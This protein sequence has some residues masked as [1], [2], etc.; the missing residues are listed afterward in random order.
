M[1]FNVRQYGAVAD[2]VTNDGP[3][4]QRAVDD[5]TAAGG[6]R[7]LVPA[8]R[9]LCGT[10]K[11]K[12][13]VELHLEMGAVLLA[14]LNPADIAMT[15]SPDSTVANRSGYFIGAYHVKNIAITGHGEING[16]GEKV[17]VDDDAD[18]GVGECPLNSDGFRPRLT[19]FEDITNLTVQDVTLANSALWTLHMAGCRHVVVQGVKIFNNPRGANNDGID[20]DSCQDVVVSDCIIETGDDAIVVKATKAMTT[21]YGPM[22]NMVIKGCVLAS[23]DSALKIGTETH[24]DI[25]NIVMSDCVVKDCSRGI[26]ILLRD[27]HVIENVQIHHIVGSVRQ[28]HSANGRSFAPD[29][30]G[31]GEPM[32][33]SATHRKGSDVAA[34][35]IRNITFD[36]IQMK[37]E[38]STFFRGEADSVIENITVRNADI[39]YVKMGTQPA[40]LFDE[41]PSERNVYP[42]E[43][44]A[45]FAKYVKG[46]TLDNISV[47]WTEPREAAWTGLLQLEDCSKVRINRV[48][49][50]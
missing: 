37:A 31:K 38:S 32:Y 20:P 3:A 28:Y 30:W 21:Q 6:G 33:L 18:H 45:F 27:G 15:E 4:I 42:H 23:H 14:S 2:G 7:V 26:G 16:Q 41:Q 29:W 49:E 9:Y 12:D 22:E 39:E 25:R 47:H 13:N 10:V 17:T 44:P 48:E 40:G 19:Y 43:I 36:N 8:G 11:L 1:E 46:L 5:C 34:G 50:I 24:G 35:T